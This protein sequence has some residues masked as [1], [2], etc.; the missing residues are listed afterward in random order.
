MDSIPF[1]LPIVS[2]TGY[3]ISVIM[4]LFRIL[5]G[6]IGDKY[7]EWKKDMNL[8]NAWKGDNASHIFQDLLELNIL[9]YCV[10]IYD[11]TI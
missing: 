1:Y 7:V 5:T 10:W 11:M 6:I 9:V 8:F 2:L 4:T 3:D